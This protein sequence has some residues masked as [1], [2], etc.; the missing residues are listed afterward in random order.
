MAACGEFF[1]T[2]TAVFAGLRRG[3]MVHR[4]SAA[5]RAL[6]PSAP[7]T[8]GGPAWLRK[9]KPIGRLFRRGRRAGVYGMNGVET[10]S[11]DDSLDA[12]ATGKATFGDTRRQILR[13]RITT[14][15]AVLPGGE[16]P[17]FSS[18]VS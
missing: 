15:G 2:T 12:E 5:A 9:R 18:C 13:L 17:A 8:L 11:K 6:S 3:A 4:L 7:S 16:V 10:W 14:G 1:G